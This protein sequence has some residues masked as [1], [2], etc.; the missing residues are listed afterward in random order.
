MTENPVF[1]DPEELWD[2]LLSRLPALVRSTFASL[3]AD[4]QNSVLAHLQR[5]A[6]EDGW[7]EEQRISARSALQAL[8]TDR[9]ASQ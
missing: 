8:E 7:H 5:M 6:D 4:Q 2:R 1:N 9:P 3:P